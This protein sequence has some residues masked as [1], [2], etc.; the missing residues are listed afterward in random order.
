MDNLHASCMNL[1]NE[2]GDGAGRLAFEEREKNKTYV[3]ERLQHF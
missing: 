2:G 1:T 3:A